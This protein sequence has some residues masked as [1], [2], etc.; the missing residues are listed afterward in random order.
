MLDPCMD[1][2][3]GTIYATSVFLQGYLD[4]VSRFPRGSRQWEFA[5][6]TAYDRM[7]SMGFSRQFSYETVYGS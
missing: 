2:I 7:I 5:A 4:M 6:N 3:A 1:N